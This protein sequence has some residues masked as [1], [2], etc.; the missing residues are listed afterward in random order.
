M[1]TVLL[2][3]PSLTRRRALSALLTQSGYGVTAL[4]DLSEAYD[5]LNRMQIGQGSVDA[6]VLGWPDYSEGIVEDVFGLLHGE[7]LEHLPVLVMAGPPTP[8][9]STGAWPGRAPPLPCG[10]NISKR[11]PPSPICCGPSKAS[12]KPQPTPGAGQGLAGG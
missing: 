4:A 12:A 11:R 3:D 7:R 8:R 1:K 6:V 10:R 9:R 2:A 5:A